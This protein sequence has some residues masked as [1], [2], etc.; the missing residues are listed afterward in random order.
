MLGENMTGDGLA[1]QSDPC[2]IE[3]PLK[4][5]FIQNIYRRKK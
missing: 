2:Y 5:V 3:E 4:A 1:K